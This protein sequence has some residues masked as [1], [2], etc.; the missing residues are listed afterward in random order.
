MDFTQRWLLMLAI[1]TGLFAISFLLLR[2]NI[3][4][5]AI[6]LGIGLPLITLWLYMDAKYFSAQRRNNISSKQACVCPVCKHQEARMCFEEKCS[7]CLITKDEK[8]VGHSS[9]PLQ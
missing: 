7:C 4:T 1:A 3:R 8:V 9:S 2:V 5:L 6:L